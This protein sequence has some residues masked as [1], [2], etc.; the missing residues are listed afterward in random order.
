MAQLCDLLWFGSRCRILLMFPQAS[1]V[2]HSSNT[3]LWDCMS[4]N[5]CKIKLVR[6]F[7]A[8]AMII[9]W[10]STTFPN[11]AIVIFIITFIRTFILVVSPLTTFGTFTRFILGVVLSSTPF[12][13]RFVFGI[14]SFCLYLLCWTYLYNCPL[15]WDATR[16]W[17]FVFW[18]SQQDI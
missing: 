16:W 1:M 10:C 12:S 3:L 5:Q 6:P 2:T 14:I 7:Q 9:T 8:T 17:S 11:G 15:G 13:C 4:W 18:Y